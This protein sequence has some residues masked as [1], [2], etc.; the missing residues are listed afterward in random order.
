MKRKTLLSIVIILVSGNLH[1]DLPIEKPVVDKDFKELITKTKAEY[2]Q[3]YQKSAQQLEEEKIEEHEAITYDKKFYNRNAL[4]KIIDK[5]LKEQITTRKEVFEPQNTYLP[6]FPITARFYD[7]ENQHLPKSVSADVL[8]RYM[9]DAIRQGSYNGVLALLDRGVKVD[10]RNKFGNT[11]LMSA[12]ATNKND[13]ATLLIL[14]GA[15][16]NLMNSRLQT[17]IHL[18]SLANNYQMVDTLLSRYTYINA[19]DT[20]GNTPMLLAGMNKNWNMVQH[21]INYGANIHTRNKNGVN[22]LHLVSAFGPY[23]LANILLQKNA[24]PFALDRN[25]ASAKDLAISNLNNS[26]ANL[27]DMAEKNLLSK[28]FYKKQELVG[29]GFF[30]EQPEYPVKS[31]IPLPKRGDNY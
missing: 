6:A 19:I 31:G 21:L 13:I 12:V 7:G 28:D 17:A 8:N 16:V 3:E 26:V 30:S 18:A 9:F 22:I 14:R 5:N 2:K 24:D 1:A 11:P 25:G 4:R 15:N 20:D 27:L 23:D 29:R 10:I